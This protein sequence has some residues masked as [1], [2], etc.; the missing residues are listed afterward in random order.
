MQ[1]RCIVRS[2]RPRAEVRTRLGA[3]KA[4]F[5]AMPC[6]S[7]L[8]RT[9]RQLLSLIAPPVRSAG[10]SA[11]MT[12]GGSGHADTSNSGPK[13]AASEASLRDHSV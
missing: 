6:S 5:P 2:S 12:D 1:R 3:T 7:G 11:G 8:Q 10:H 13:W 4:T 9:P